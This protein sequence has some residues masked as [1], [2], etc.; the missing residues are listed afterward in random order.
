MN[1]YFKFL[2]REPQK[3]IVLMQL[4]QR[5]LKMMLFSSFLFGTALY[6]I[7]LIPVLQKG[8]YSTI[9]L[10]TVFYIWIILITFVPRLPYSVR[11]IC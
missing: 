5:L 10:Y 4:R 2:F 7:A 6:L 1:N 11:A 8:L 9:L 3:N